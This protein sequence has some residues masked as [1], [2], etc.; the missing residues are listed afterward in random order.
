MS[1][2]T[3]RRYCGYCGLIHVQVLLCV[4]PVVNFVCGLAMFTDL[5]NYN[6][7]LLLCLAGVLKVSTPQCLPMDRWVG[8]STVVIV[9][10]PATTDMNLIIKWPE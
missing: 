10:C 7:V 4:F 5:A 8:P 6:C 1:V 9:I 2:C 3:V